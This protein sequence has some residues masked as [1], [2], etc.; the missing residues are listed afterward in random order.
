MIREENKKGKVDQNTFNSL[1]IK[2]LDKV[3]RQLEMK[4][5]HLRPHWS[6]D[7]LCYRTESEESYQKNKLLFLNLGELL[8]ESEVN[9]RLIST[10]KLFEPIHYH[11]REIQLIELPAPKKGKPTPEG[12]EHI[13]VVCDRSLEDLAAQYSH[14]SVQTKGMEKDFNRELEI[15]LEG[16]AIKFHHLSLESVIHLEENTKVFH[17]LKSSEVLNILSPY[18]PQIVGTFPL[19]L[20]Q[21]NSDLDILLYSDN[22]T[23]L[24]VVLKKAFS[25]MNGFKIYT[26]KVDG[27]DSLIANF[28]FDKVPFELF[29]QNVPT[30]EQ[31]A[32]RHFQTEE[33]LLKL[34]GENFFHS[35][36][37]FR[38]VGL[39][40]EPAF[41]SA[42]KLSGNSYQ[43]I[44]DLFLLSESELKSRY[45]L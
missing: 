14:L 22:L 26:H 21:A 8:I 29:V 18:S 38:Q 20:H 16:C 27:I 2:F 34:G 12:L 45:H 44:S 37:R 35:V 32:F 11:G 33:K 40:T 17:A 39:K 42:L 15:E 7:H 1:S 30:H 9:T 3:F 13:E 28:T 23:E 19:A 31:V 36:C 4:G 6:I 43:A 41:A 10:F 24:A 5:I 25:S